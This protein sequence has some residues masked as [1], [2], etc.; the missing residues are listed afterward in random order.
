MGNMKSGYIIYLKE[1]F[2]YLFMGLLFFFTLSSICFYYNSSQFAAFFMLCEIIPLFFKR[3]LSNS[4]T[5]EISLDYRHDVIDII[6]KKE[7]YEEGKLFAIKLNELKSYSISDYGPKYYNISFT[8][9]NKKHKTYTFYRKKL[10]EDVDPGDKIIDDIYLLIKDYNASNEQKI[11][12]RPSFL[13]SI[14]GLIFMIIFSGTMLCAMA[15]IFIKNNNVI[16]NNPFQAPLLIT[17]F[18]IQLFHMWIYRYRAIK[19]YKQRCK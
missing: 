10:S 17:C 6:T 3:K 13:G 11:I 4:L 18:F 12:L 14:L 15:S 5:R 2:L 19:H 1:M 8:L 7:D 16:K 9:K